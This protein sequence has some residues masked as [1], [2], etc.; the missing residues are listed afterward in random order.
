VAYWRLVCRPKARE[1]GRQRRVAVSARL[2]GMTTGPDAISDGEA[3]TEIFRAIDGAS[4][5][6]Y[7]K[8]GKA[9]DDLELICRDPVTLQR[10]ID[11]QERWEHRTDATI[12][13][14]IWPDAEQL[15]QAA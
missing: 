9:F 15:E 12:E 2:K 14:L 4:H 11:R 5:D 13:K 6:A 1:F 3:L 7:T 8:D 10:F